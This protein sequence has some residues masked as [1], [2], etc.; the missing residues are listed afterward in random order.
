MSWYY[1]FYYHAEIQYHIYSLGLYSSLMS[2]GFIAL[3]L[4][5]NKNREL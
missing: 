3:Y 4:K 5:R 2:L 1:W